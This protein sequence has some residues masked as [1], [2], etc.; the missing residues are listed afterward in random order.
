[1]R[2]KLLWMRA[3][4]MVGFEQGGLLSKII[5]TFAFVWSAVEV[6]YLFPHWSWIAVS[7]FILYFDYSVVMIALGQSVLKRVPV[8]TL[9]LTEVG[10]SVDSEKVA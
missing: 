3:A 1:M 9:P 7:L 6:I 8:T 10:T 4:F 5:T 2:E